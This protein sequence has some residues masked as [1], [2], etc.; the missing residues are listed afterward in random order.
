M[1]SSNDKYDL[2]TII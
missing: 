1:E 2:N